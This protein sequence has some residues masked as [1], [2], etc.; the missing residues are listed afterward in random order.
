MRWLTR[1]QYSSR[2]DRGAVATI[3]TVLVSFGV[4]IGMLAIS[5]DV[6][7]VTY[8]RRSVQNAADASANA[9][10]QACVE[11]NTAVCTTSAAAATALTSLATANAAGSTVTSVCMNAIG[12]ASMPSLASAPDLCTAT[13]TS[14]DLGSCLPVTTTMAAYPYVE[15]R[16]RTSASTPF[17]AAL[18]SSNT[19]PVPACARSAWG[20]G[21]PSQVN[22]LP[23]AMSECD[24]AHQTGWPS[25]TN[26][27]PA[28][29]GAAPG[30]SNTDSRPDWPSFEDAIY[31]KGNP[32]TCDTSSPGGTAPGGFAWLDGL[33]GPCS[34]VVTDNSWIHGDTGANGC[35]SSSFDS[36]QGT[37]VYV[38]VFDCMMSSDPGRDPISTDDCKSGNGNNTYYHIGGFAAFY[39]SGWRLTNG[40]KN[41]V[42][43]PY[44]LCGSGNDDRCVSGWFIQ[45]LIPA[46]SFVPPTPTNPN[47]GIKIIGPAG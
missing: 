5:A 47:Y 36:L 32:T 24:W 20:P 8:Q 46:G 1:L 31:A 41:S 33:T 25:S 10:A 16:T 17:G 22:V 18:G 34:G 12:R 13:S 7:S 35:S 30:Y 6:G 45:D 37:V 29:D 23:L 2:R 38:P 21:N 19:R 43:P 27:P 42:R 44:G 40:S 3:V 9:L 28:P 4:V 26:Y 39:L 11:Q 15:V 14:S